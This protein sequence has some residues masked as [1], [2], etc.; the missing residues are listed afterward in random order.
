MTPDLQVDLWRKM[1]FLRAVEMHIAKEYPK[2]EMRCPTHLSVG[3]ELTPALLSFFLTHEDYAVSTHRGHVHYLSKGGSLPKMIAELFGRVTGCSRGYGGS[4][5]LADSDVRF[6]GTSAIVGNSIP[7]GAGLALKQKINSER[8][9]T[10]VY[11]GD[12]ATEE[13]VFYE[14]VNFCAVRNLPILFVCENNLYSVYSGLEDR[15][16]KNL[17]LH[18]LVAGMGVESY[19]C[20]ASDI[21]ESYDT[22]HDIFFKMRSPEKCAPVFIEIDTY[23]FLEHCGPSNDDD[24]GYRSKAEVAA[25][26]SVDPLNCLTKTIEM[27]EVLQAYMAEVDMEV[28]KAFEFARSSEY[29]SVSDIRF[30]A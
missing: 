17:S 15:R 28:Q 24:L 4:M 27:T 22:F 21:A 12:G 10:V 29:P 25:F 16:P 7:V 8:G 5:H 1:Y 26:H 30:K 18:T 20:R 14:T 11:L 9:V 19:R 3:Q 13:G 23:R 6:M 2:G